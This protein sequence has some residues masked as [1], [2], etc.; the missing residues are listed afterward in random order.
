M[1]AAGARYYARETVGDEPSLPS[2]ASTGL[3]RS[4]ATPVA[5]NCTGPIENF[6][7]VV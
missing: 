3:N 2:R 7:Y 1:M 6:E 5:G 4:C